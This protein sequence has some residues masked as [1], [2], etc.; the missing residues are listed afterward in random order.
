MPVHWVHD[1]TRKVLQRETPIDWICTT[2]GSDL[3]AKVQHPNSTIA[4][5]QTLQV[6]TLVLSVRL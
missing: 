2:K 3:S 1:S 5:R 6:V 4:A